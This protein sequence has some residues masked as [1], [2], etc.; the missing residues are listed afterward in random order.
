MCI[1]FMDNDMQLVHF[2]GKHACERQFERSNLVHGITEISSK[3]GTS[4]HQ[5][6]PYVILCKMIHQN[7]MAFAVVFLCCTVEAIKF[8]QK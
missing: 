8:R 2:Y 4:S 1:D 5:H 3:R 7:I 6:N